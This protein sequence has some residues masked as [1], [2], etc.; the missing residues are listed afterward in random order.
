MRYSL[1]RTCFLYLKA[2][3]LPKAFICLYSS[4]DI[5]AKGLLDADVVLWGT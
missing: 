5:Y 1:Q 2:T 3:K 4:S